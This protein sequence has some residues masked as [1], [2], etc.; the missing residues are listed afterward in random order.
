MAWRMPAATESAA[1]QATCRHVAA[2]RLRALTEWYPTIL[3]HSQLPRVGAPVDGED[4]AH[5]L[6]LLRNQL[7]AP[8]LPVGDVRSGLP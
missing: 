2:E 8:A 1:A 7:R 4:L 3:D 6:L 5:R